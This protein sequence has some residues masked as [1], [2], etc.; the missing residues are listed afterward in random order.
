V[1]WSLAPGPRF[2][3]LSMGREREQHRRHEPLRQCW[4]G[5]A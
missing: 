4:A 1:D 3:R 2:G 5:T